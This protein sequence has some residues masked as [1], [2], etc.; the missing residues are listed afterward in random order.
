MVVLYISFY[1]FVFGK[2]LNEYVS[3][4]EDQHNAAFHRGLTVC[5][6]TKD[7]QTKA[8]TSV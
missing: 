8:Y 4:T 6:G 3:N 1:P 7:R 5:Q 2:S